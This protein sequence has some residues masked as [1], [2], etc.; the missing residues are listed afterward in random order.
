MPVRPLSEADRRWQSDVRETS[1]NS[2]ITGFL[3]LI[4]MAAV[5]AW[6][7]EKWLM[8]VMLAQ[9][10]VMLA[11]ACYNFGMARAFLLCSPPDEEER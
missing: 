6:A 8:W 2:Q 11:I 1:G 10:A 9:A 5:A 7:D 4:V 3:A